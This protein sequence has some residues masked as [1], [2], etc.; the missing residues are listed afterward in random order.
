MK[1]SALSSAFLFLFSLTAMAQDGIPTILQKAE[2]AN[3]SNPDYRFLWRTDPGVRYHLQTSDTLDSWT[4][5]PGY[6]KEAEGPVEFHDFPPTPGGKHFIQAIRLDEQA[7]TI[8]SRYPDEGAYAIPRFTDFSI[9]LEDATGVDEASI[10]LTVG[11]QSAMTVAGTAGLTF[12]DGLLRF[13]AVDTAHGAY[14]EIVPVSLVVVDTLGN[15]ATYQWSFK[16][17][18]EGQLLVPKMVV[19]GSASAQRAGQR[20]S[21][22]QREVANA[23]VGP[24]RVPA[25]SGGTY[26]VS[27]V[28]ADYLV[29]TY[30]GATAP[31]FAV[32][33]HVANQCPTS[34]EEIF[35]RRIT[36]VVDDTVAKTLTLGTVEVEVS[37]LEAGT[38]SVGPD[39]Q[40]FNV[41]PNGNFQPAG[42]ISAEVVF[43]SLGVSNI[44]AGAGVAIKNSSQT[45]IASLSA[46]EFGFTFTPSLE[47]SVET[48]FGSL[49]SLEL[50]LKG[51]MDYAAIFNLTVRTP[52]VSLEKEIY[53]LPTAQ[54]P[55][56]V[57]Y[58]GQLGVIP[59][60]A[61]L[62]FDLTIDV[63]LNAAAVLQTDFGMRRSFEQEL[64]L[65][66]VKGSDPDFKMGQTSHGTEPVPFD[67]QLS[68]D[69]DATVTVTPAVKFLIY[70]VAG[71]EANVAAKA[72]LDLTKAGGDPVTADFGLNLD[73]TIKPAGVALDFLSPPLKAGK[74]WSLWEHKRDLIAELNK[75][76]TTAYDGDGGLILEQVSLGT[77]DTAGIWNPNVKKTLFT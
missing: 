46:T 68:G 75:L 4:T 27:T 41:L 7:P 33:D 32:D 61:D 71:I 58:L 42:S 56:K 76:T 24:V 47:A 8:I 31:V 51:R 73:L 59:V 48:R 62:R 53:N 65:E 45:T 12:V 16:L 64:K 23:T 35:Y 6:P 54:E 74:S 3:P 10:S 17:E 38:A 29:L 72:D 1:T 13:D 44:L 18:V 30:T 40:V 69:L 11:S 49:Q 70:G 25:G 43:P 20:L 60:F 36:S 57:L 77:V 5:V 14:E 39:S 19:F 37:V 66:Y 52:S 67:L 21:A 28:A 9:R 22:S 50:S 26:V 55:H 63:S 2:E 34:P 15:S